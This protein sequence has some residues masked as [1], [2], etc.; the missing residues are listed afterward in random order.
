MSAAGEPESN[1]SRRRLRG[2]NPLLW[3]AAVIGGLIVF[4]ILSGD[5]GES[6]AT[7]VDPDP[8]STPAGAIER[9]LLLPP[10][11]RARDYI[12]Q[13]RAG[14]KPYPLD[15]VFARAG[16]H[17]A[18]GNL[19]D[20]HLLYFFAAREDHLPAVM[21]L[22][23]MADPTRFSAADSLLDEADVI[24]AHKWYRKAAALGDANAAVRL[25]ELQRWAQGA[26]A[27]DDPGAAQILLNY[28]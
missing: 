8:E 20:A 3:I 11:M 27:A 18:D 6:I 14:G 2:R 15:E 19:A 5:R 17:L 26:A 28:R 24:Q 21:A 4:V 16:E 25:D 7:L 23:E 22:G 1:G 9:S 13:L 10:G 12:E